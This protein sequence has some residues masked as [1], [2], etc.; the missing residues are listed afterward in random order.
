MADDTSQMPSESPADGTEDMTSGAIP[1]PH[2][3]V[4]AE[5]AGRF[6]DAGFL[7]VPAH[8]SFPQDIVL[9]PVDVYHDL[10][11]ACRQ[12]GF[13]T[14]IDVCGVDY[15]HRSPRYEVVVNL[16]DMARTA[17]VRIRV[18]VS[19]TEPDLP[20]I[21]DIFPGAN[22]Y[23]RETYDLFG[24]RFTGHPALTRILLPDDWEGHPLRKDYF[25]GS[26]PVQFKGSP[27]AS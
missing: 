6:P 5:L 1:I 16:L 27:K 22:F 4:L 21:S 20:T 12:G 24:I 8:D 13:D 11:D 14:F 10:V 7:T 17:R 26:V 23:E 18:G 2:D 15:H 9:P 3:P 19:G 25:V